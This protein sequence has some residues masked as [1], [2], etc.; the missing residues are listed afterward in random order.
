MLSLVKKTNYNTKVVEIDTK[1]SSLDGKI[2]KNKN[3][4][5]K[6]ENNIALFLGGIK[7]LTVKMVLKLI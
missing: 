2:T 1:L 5:S 6:T 7:C 3:E 4:L